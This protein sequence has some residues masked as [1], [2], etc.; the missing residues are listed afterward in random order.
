MCPNISK[1]EEMACTR[2]TKPTDIPQL[3]GPNDLIARNL[4][5]TNKVRP[6]VSRNARSGNSQ[7]GLL[8]AADLLP[9]CTGAASPLSTE[10]VIGLSD[11]G[12]NLKEIMILALRARV[13]ENAMQSLAMA[14]GEEAAVGVMEFWGDELT[15]DM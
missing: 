10:Q 13:D 8:S 4:D 12:G 11:L 14:V 3:D 5:A 2:S 15:A 1:N 9:W 7:Q 6:P